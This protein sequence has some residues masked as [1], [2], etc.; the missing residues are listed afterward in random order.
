MQQ[1][2]GE[3]TQSPWFLWL[4]YTAPHTP[5][6][7]PPTHLL[8]NNS[9]SGNAIDINQNPLSYYLAMLEALDTEMARLLEVVDMENTIIIFIGDNGTP[10]QVAQ[11][12]YNKS[13]A[14]ASVY[15]GGIN[16]PMVVAGKGVSRIGEREAALINSTDLFATIADIADTGTDAIH[17]SLSFKGLLSGTATVTRTFTYAEIIAGVDAWTIRNTQ[18]KLLEFSDGTQELYD[19]EQDPYESVELIS[20]GLIAEQSA[21]KLALEQLAT[22]IRSSQ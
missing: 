17:D 9:L 7:L 5:F 4:A 12:P 11:A 14:K 18:Y 20:L 6:H 1:Q 10:A 21:A 13:H 22:S 19:L 15:Q 8:S 2:T 3:N 16:T